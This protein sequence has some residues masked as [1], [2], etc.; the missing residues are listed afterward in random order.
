M[1]IS[2]NLKSQSAYTGSNGL[3]SSVKLT[4]NSKLQLV[5]LCKSVDIEV[6]E[7]ELHCTVIYS[8]KHV[9]DLDAVRSYSRKIYEATAD[10]IKWWEGHDKAGYLV[11]G[12][13][14]QQ[15]SDEHIRLKKLG[16]EPTFDEYSP[17]ITLMTPIRF[18]SLE[19][20][21]YNIRL[22]N[23]TLRR[24]PLELQFDSQNVDDLR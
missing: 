2:I 10:Q 22:G 16:C 4:Q 3:Y 20:L 13:T 15:L 21:K 7:K 5:N 12:L 23:L 18:E 17:H 24:N 14:S 8:E 9:S 11:L 1:R 6:D 19:Q